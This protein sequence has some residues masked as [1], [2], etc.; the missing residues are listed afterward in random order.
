MGLTPPGQLVSLSY[1]CIVGAILFFVLSV[2]RY[3]VGVVAR[4]N[5]KM[6]ATKATTKEISRVHPIPS[7]R[8]C[9]AAGVL[10]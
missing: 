8:F 9:S 2:R 10:M 7:F 1:N 3:W 4:I 5:M 6:T